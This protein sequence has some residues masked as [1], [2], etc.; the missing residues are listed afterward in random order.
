MVFKVFST[1]AAATQKKMF[2]DCFSLNSALIHAYDAYHTFKLN[3]EHPLIFLVI[4]K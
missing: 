1:I 3:K 2:E 4:Q